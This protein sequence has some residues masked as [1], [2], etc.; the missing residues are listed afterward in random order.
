MWANA[1]DQ[2]RLSGDPEEIKYACCPN[3]DHIT[4]ADIPALLEE[5]NKN[6]LIK[7]YNT[8]KMMA[9]QLLDWWNVHR[10]QWAWPSEYALPKR[11]QDHLRYKR[12]AKE[13]VKDNWFSQVSH[14]INSGEQDSQRP[15]SE[16]VDGFRIVGVFG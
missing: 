11:W 3:I 12:G 2:G 15:L 4:K 10:P 7:I 6:Q 13:V 5:L 8:S 16:S 14:K 1:D 9:I